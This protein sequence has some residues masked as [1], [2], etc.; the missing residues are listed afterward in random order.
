MLDWRKIMRPNLYYVGYWIWEQPKSQPSIPVL[1][2]EYMHSLFDGL[3][4]P[5]PWEDE[6]MGIKNGGSMNNESSNQRGN[7][8]R[9]SA[10][11]A[12]TNKKG[13]ISAYFRLFQPI[14]GYF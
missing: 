9:R 3:D 12:R 1:G 10:V 14:S 4:T 11:A 6:M 13:R 2:V 8:E 5:C 7:A